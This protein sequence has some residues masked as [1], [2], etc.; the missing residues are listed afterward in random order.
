MSPW[1]LVPAGLALG[2]SGAGLI[3]LYTVANQRARRKGARAA[4]RVGWM[5]GACGMAG[6]FGGW[7]LL[8]LAGPHLDGAALRASGAAALLGA[9]GIYGCGARRVGRWRAPSRYMLELQTRGI[10]ARVRHP[11]A[12]AL[13]L[14][15]AGAGLATG[16]V[17][18]LL[19]LPLWIGF[20][21]AYTYLEERFELIPAFGERYLR[22]RERVPRLLPRL[23]GAPGAQG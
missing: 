8:C 5:L 11:Q 15:A 13:C 23:P 16:S 19:T 4:W 17:P 20:W 22:Y 14:A 2:L 21:V 3:A 6:M 1:V 18:Y 7:G 9:L 10:Y 12:L